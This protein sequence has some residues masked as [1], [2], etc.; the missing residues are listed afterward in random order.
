MK[1]EILKKVQDEGL[2]ILKLNERLEQAN[3]EHTFIDRR[4]ERM[5]RVD[6]ASIDFVNEVV[7]FDFQI[8][9]EENENKISLIQSPFSYGI[10]QNLIEVY[11]FQNEPV[12][13]EH[14]MA[15][16]LIVKKMLNSYI[17]A[18]NNKTVEDIK[19]I[20]LSLNN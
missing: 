16:V 14:E 20:F 8:F 3:I 19:E 1:N 15:A 11:N 7:P 4:Y 18:V 2:A 9:I 17:I 13:L 5:K 10:N 12:V 6:Q